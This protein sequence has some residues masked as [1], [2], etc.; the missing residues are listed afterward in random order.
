MPDSIAKILSVLDGV[1][2]RGRGQWYAK[3]PAHDDKSPS[4]SIKETSDGTVLIHCFGG[5][6]VH[7][8]VAA[9]GLELRDLF[10]AN[11]VHYR[12]GRRPRWN[13]RDLLKLLSHEMTLVVI[14]AG[15]LSKG[16]PLTDEGKA[17]L[18]KAYMRLN[19]ILEVTHAID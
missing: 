17:R 7:D 13:P 1:R 4:L 19:K 6:S 14:V 8:V 11:D 3:C 9:V 15:E 2:D 18:H 5:C 10:P 16:N 12:P